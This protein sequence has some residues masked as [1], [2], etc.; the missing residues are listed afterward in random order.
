[1]MDTRFLKRLL[2]FRISF[3]LIKGYQVVDYGFSFYFFI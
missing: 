2:E 1:M 3:W